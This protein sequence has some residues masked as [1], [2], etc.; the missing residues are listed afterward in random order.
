MKIGILGAG[1]VGGALGTGWAQAG[2]E[3]MFSSRDPR[4]EKVQAM[5]KAAGARARAGTPAETVAFGT[6][7]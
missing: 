4:G 6:W 7:S 5:V 3:V 1:N 2:H